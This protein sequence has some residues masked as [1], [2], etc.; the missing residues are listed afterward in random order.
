MGEE[1]TRSR[2][3][4][5][6]GEEQ[7]DRRWVKP[8]YRLN[9]FTLAAL[10]AC[11]KSQ[12]APQVALNYTVNHISTIEC[13]ATL[14]CRSRVEASRNLFPRTSAVKSDLQTEAVDEQG[15][16]SDSGDDSE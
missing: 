6:T 2:N 12:P 13:R 5:E 7:K 1:E 4:E 8:S 10:E 15:E 9:T 16:Y 14:R 3:E 11:L